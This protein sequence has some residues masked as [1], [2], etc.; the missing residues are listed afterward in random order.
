MTHAAA[1]PDTPSL[2]EIASLSP[3]EKIKS[4]L[5][6]NRSVFAISDTTSLAE[7]A[8]DAPRAKFTTAKLKPAKIPLPQ[9]ADSMSIGT[10]A[11]VSASSDSSESQE[12]V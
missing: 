5:T 11:A 3:A 8:I 12:Y 7:F 2:M 9:S 1:A 6:K 10:N 4:T